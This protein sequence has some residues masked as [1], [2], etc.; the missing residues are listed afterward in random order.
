M[1]KKQFNRR[2]FFQHSLALT[3]GAPVAL[4]FLP[5]ALW[6][7]AAPASAEKTVY[8]AR[9]SAAKV[10]I[11]SCRSYGPE[12]RAAMEKSFDLIGGIG[13]LVRNK[14]VAVKL[15]LTGTTFAPFLGRPVGETYMTHYATAAALAASLF[16]AGARR[17]RFLE[18][19]ASKATLAATVAEGGWD[20]RALE[21]L[22]QVE[23]E[24]TR[25]LGTGRK[26]VPFSVPGRGYM[27]SSFE[28]NHAYAEADVFVSLA[29]LKNHL[30]AGVT[31]SM[32]NLFGLPP[33]TLY[34]SQTGEDAVGVRFPL[35]DP[36]GHERIQLPGLKSKAAPAEPG[37]RVPRITVDICAAR[38]IDLAIIDGI[39]AMRGGEGPWCVKG[40]K[41]EPTSPGL[42][43]A[44]FNPV[45]TDAVATAAMG[46]PDPRAQGVRPFESCDNHLLLAE[47]A[48]LGIADLAQ[49]DVRGLAVE[50]ARYPYG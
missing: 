27:F 21:A 12:V 44:G 32:K 10:A 35:H 14:T 4:R 42:L 49:I 18:S 48:G 24:N 28:L 11:V 29:K 37:R 45:S 41:V 46:Y 40:S 34:G 19:T 33:N 50:K 6:A 15:N 9:Q 23:F 36:K 25:N 47:E 39:T 22:G 5:R 2:T 31:L 26:Y 20:L 17:V 8:S 13:S 3:A 43:I 38:P 30:T 1:K 16:G 7:A